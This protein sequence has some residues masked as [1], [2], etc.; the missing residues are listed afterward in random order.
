[1]DAKVRQAQ[2]LVGKDFWHHLTGAEDFYKRLIETFAQVAIQAN[3]KDLIEETI[4]TLA[5]S[6]ELQPFKS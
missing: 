1:M 4:A 5:K 6:P 3:G 2:L